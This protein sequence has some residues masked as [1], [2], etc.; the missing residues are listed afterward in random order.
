MEFPKLFAIFMFLS[1]F[2]KT[3]Y[4]IYIII[5]LRDY[6]A[7]IKQIGQQNVTILLTISKLGFDMFVFKIIC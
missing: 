4:H 6:Q 1:N 7:N 5:Y 2:L 3:L